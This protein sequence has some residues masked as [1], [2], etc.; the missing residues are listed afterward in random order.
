MGD[1]IEGQRP[2]QPGRFVGPVREI[3]R[4]KE[5]EKESVS[6]ID[7]NTISAITQAVVSAMDNMPTKTVVVQGNDSKEIADD[8]KSEDSMAKLAD[9]MVIQ[10]EGSESNFKDLGRVKKTKKDKDEV[11]KTIDIL[12]DID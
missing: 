3:V 6:Q 4:I 10:R 8:F 9:A 12:K 5:V 7:A 1:Y 11:D 2:P